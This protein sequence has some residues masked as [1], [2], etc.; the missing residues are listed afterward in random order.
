MPRALH[1]DDS[2]LTLEYSG[3]MLLGT[4]HRRLRVPWSAVVGVATEPYDERHGAHGRF[5]RH[6]RSLFASF[7]D[8]RRVVRLRL[9]RRAPGA[10][11][12]DEIVLGAENPAAF[13]ARVCSRLS[14]ARPLAA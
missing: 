11:A 14:A 6:G 13:A 1:L 9:D 7:D 4:L 10:P 3:L 5:R 12:Y 2:G 8:P